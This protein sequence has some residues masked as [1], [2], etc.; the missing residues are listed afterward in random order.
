MG[1]I[2]FTVLVVLW[3]VFSFG[4][5]GIG[6]AMGGKPNEVISA[7]KC[8]GFCLVVFT[9]PI[10][11]WFMWPINALGYEVP[12]LGAPFRLRRRARSE[13]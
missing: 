3:A 11:I 13:E 5:A 12:Y 10:W 8:I 6:L 2:V 9:V 1:W 7:W 4:L